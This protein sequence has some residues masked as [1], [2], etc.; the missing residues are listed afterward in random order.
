M[1]KILISII[2]GVSISTASSAGVDLDKFET[3]LALY[4][5]AIQRMCA[6]AHPES[7]PQIEKTLT[8]DASLPPTTK[9]KMKKF[10]TTT[11]PYVKGMLDGAYIMAY[12][13]DMLDATCATFSKPLN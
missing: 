4:M 10:K 1:L 8:M 12:D 9:E 6:E 7:A 13:K 11:D 3:R 5:L 2:A